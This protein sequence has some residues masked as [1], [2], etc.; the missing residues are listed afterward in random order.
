[1]MIPE[2]YLLQVQRRLLLS[3]SEVERR[4]GAAK[5]LQAESVKHRHAC[6]EARNTAAK[7]TRQNS[8]FQNP[9]SSVCRVRT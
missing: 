8:G 6:E 9:S 2:K 7:V 5:M 3:R 1:M 4:R